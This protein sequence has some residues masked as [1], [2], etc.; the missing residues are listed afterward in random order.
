MKTPF[1]RL[2]PVL[3]LCGF[4]SSALW[5]QAQVPRFFMF[6]AKSSPQYSRILMKEEAAR[7]AAYAAQTTAAQ[8]VHAPL[9]QAEKQLA[10]SANFATRNKRLLWNL[11][12]RAGISKRRAL[13]NLQKW[14]LQPPA[15]PKYPPLEKESFR[16]KDFAGL[17][18]APADNV[19]ATPLY[20]REGRV[21]SGM[22]LNAD[23]A[24]L[25]R[26]LR[27]GLLSQPA[28]EKDAAPIPP[29]ALTASPSSALLDAL[30]RGRGEQRIPVIFTVQSNSPGEPAGKMLGAIAL[31]KKEGAPRW[32]KITPQADGFLIT[33]YAAHP[34]PP[35]VQ[36]ELWGL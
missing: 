10:S 32:Y 30:R 9:V 34:L 14:G 3:I 13:V 31:L 35:R 25:R 2:L 7:R 20:A 19:P 12:T 28:A 5:A 8:T 17:S 29:V 11:Q 4:S 23:G 27:Q 22:G 33:P 24:D 21:F 18:P 36:K 15:H 6:L 16:V 26:I 1:S